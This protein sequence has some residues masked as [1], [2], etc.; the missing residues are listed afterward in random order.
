M[1]FPLSINEKKRGEITRVKVLY[2]RLISWLF[3]LVFCQEWFVM[4]SARYKI[5]HIEDHEDF[6]MIVI[7][8][9]FLGSMYVLGSFVRELPKGEIVRT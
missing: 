2:L 9:K 8:N 4:G 6:F 5:I 7:G 3:N 1:F